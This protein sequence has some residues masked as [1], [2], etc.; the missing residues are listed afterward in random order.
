MHPELDDVANHMIKIGLGV[1]SQAQKNIFYCDY[2]ALNGGVFGVLQAAHAAEIIIKACIAQQHPLLIFSSLPKS[3]NVNGTLLD[4]NS[5]ISSGKTIDYNDLPEKLWSTTGYKI[6]ELNLYN[7]FGKLRNTIQHFAV[8]SRDL[9]R[10][11]G[12]F[13]Y[14]VI[15]PLIGH[16]WSLY[17][18]EYCDSEELEYS[19]LPTLVSY[20]ISFR[21]PEKWGF[22]VEKAK[23]ELI[24]N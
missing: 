10:E 14:R 1:L 23:K 2:T 13:I 19:L 22:Y 9:N 18:V 24:E 15:D 16:F 7:S 21:Y 3:S 5:L 4:M 8:P 12:E 20:G 11:A 17:A 6:Q